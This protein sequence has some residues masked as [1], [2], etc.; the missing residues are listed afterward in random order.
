MSASI[1]ARCREENARLRQA[2]D[3]SLQFQSHYATLLNQYDGGKRL[4][5]TTVDEWLSGLDTT[6]VLIQE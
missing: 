4:Q 6:V 1:L 5:F 2:L 3:R